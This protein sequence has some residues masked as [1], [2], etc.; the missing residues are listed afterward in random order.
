MENLRI[1]NTLEEEL[2]NVD[3]EVG[4]RLRFR[5]TMLGMSQDQLGTATG[6]SFQQIQKYEKGSNRVG[7]SR[8]FEFAKVLSVD[9]NYFFTELFTKSHVDSANENGISL[10]FE[11]NLKPF[12]YDNQ[13]EISSKEVMSLVKA[14]SQIKESKVRK[15]VLA[16][17]QS[18]SKDNED[19]ISE[20]AEDETVA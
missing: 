20:E 4:K 7:A 12:N 9:V 5:R 2:K 6:V 8:L 13:P 10:S 1:S 3:I 18:L 19:L 14:Y 11:E 17:V 15:K 16:L